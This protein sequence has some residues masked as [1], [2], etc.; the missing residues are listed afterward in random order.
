MRAELER[1]EAAAFVVT[2][3]NTCAAAAVVKFQGAPVAVTLPA[4]F[5]ATTFQ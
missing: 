3:G 1:M 2:V 4:E 5:F